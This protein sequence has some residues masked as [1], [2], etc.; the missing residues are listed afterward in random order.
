MHGNKPCY[1][2]TG[3]CFGCGKLGH[4][5]RDCPENKMLMLDSPKEDSREDR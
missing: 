4:I 3:A 1:R 2:E 5:I